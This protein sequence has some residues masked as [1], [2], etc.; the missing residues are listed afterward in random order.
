MSISVQVLD[1][2]H[3]H[4]AANM[5][6]RLARDIGGT[7]HEQASGRTDSDGRLADWLPTPMGRGIHKLEFELDE[8]FAGIGITPLYPRITVVFRVTDLTVSCDIQ[9]LITPY[10]DAIYQRPCGIFQKPYLPATCV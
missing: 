4:P 1:C 2:A 3:G 7:A 9:L 10:A 5:A 6:V 8:Y